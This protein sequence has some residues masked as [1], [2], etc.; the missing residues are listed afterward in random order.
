LKSANSTVRSN[1]NRKRALIRYSCILCSQ[2]I[3]HDQRHTD[4]EG[5][6]IPLDEI[7]KNHHDCL[8]LGH[9]DGQQTVT[10]IVHNDYKEEYHTYED[11]IAGHYSRFELDFETRCRLARI[12]YWYIERG[13]D[14]DLDESTSGDSKRR[15]E[16][17]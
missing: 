17:T 8:A 16:R 5:K 2:I 12:P 14:S 1:T 7:G 15:I 13:I 4:R 9:R 6:P 10:A 11:E 3:R